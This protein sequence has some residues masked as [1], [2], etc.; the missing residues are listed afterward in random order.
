[1][2]EIASDLAK[3][4]I[5][6]ILIQIH[7][8]HSSAWPMGLE[9]QPEPNKSFTDRVQRAQE[10]IQSDSPPFPVYI[11][12]WSD[13]FEQTFRA[14]PDK[15]YAINSDKIVQMKS[16]YGNKSDALID[17]DLLVYLET[18]LKD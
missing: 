7:E 14:W 10:Y 18:L 8:A 2:Y 13:A 15:Y 17:I 12:G 5:Q 3:K 16:T 9:S 6:I 11:D 4:G 1:M